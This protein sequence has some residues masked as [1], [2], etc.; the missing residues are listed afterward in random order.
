METDAAMETAMN[1]N[2]RV[3]IPHR[4]FSLQSA[5]ANFTIS[6]PKVACSILVAFTEDHKL[7]AVLWLLGDSEC[8]QSCLLF[9]NIPPPPTICTACVPQGADNRAPDSLPQSSQGNWPQPQSGQ[10]LAAWAGLAQL[11]QEHQVSYSRSL[12]GAQRWKGVFQVTREVPV[13]AGAGEGAWVGCTSPVG[14]AGPTP[15]ELC[16]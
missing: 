5:D 15:L 16:R 9:P 12:N 1:I 2:I 6:L 13:P 7:P 14:Q 11:K 4:P 3:S 8:R 10:A